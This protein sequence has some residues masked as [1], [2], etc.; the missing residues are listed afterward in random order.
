MHEVEL[1][2]RHSVGDDVMPAYRQVGVGESFE[3]GVSRSVARTCPPSPTRSQ[4]HAAIEPPPPP[5]SQ[6]RQPGPTPR[7]SK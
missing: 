6:Q 3:E 5:I 7:V 1:V 2:L 4:S